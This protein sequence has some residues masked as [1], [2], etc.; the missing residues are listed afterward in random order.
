MG[1]SGI[2]LKAEG[3][4]LW[5]AVSLRSCGGLG[6]ALA[7]LLTKWQRSRSEQ[8]ACAIAV[9]ALIYEGRTRGEE[10]AAST[11]TGPRICPLTLPARAEGPAPCRR[12]AIDARNGDERRGGSPAET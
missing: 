4:F 2:A 10:G 11:V 5:M 7:S 12:G 1:E 3:A 8:W 6:G 9:M